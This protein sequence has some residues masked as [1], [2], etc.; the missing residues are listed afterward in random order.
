VNDQT[1]SPTFT[2]NLVRNTLTLIEEER[3]G[4]YHQTAQGIISWVHFAE[5]IFEL[6]GKKVSVNRI[7]SDDYP[8]KAVRP[9]Y[10]KLSTEKIEQLPGIE[11]E[12]W[13]TGLRGLLEQIKMQG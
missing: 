4:T 11:T 12:Y 2:H 13:K 8:A 3:E 6:A 1:G 9:F 5:G 10:S 7:S